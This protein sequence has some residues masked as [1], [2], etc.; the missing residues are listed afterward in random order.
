MISNRE[1]PFFIEFV[2]NSKV[3][4]IPFDDLFIKINPNIIN[5]IK[6]QKQYKVKSNV[7][8]FIFLDFIEYLK[9]KKS[10]K[11]QIENIHEYD[12]LSQ[13][14]EVMKDLVHIYK[15]YENFKILPLESENEELKTEIQSQK[16]ILN[17]KK[18]K[19]KQIINILFFNKGIEKFSSHYNKVKIQEACEQENIDLVNQSSRTKVVANDIYYILDENEKTASISA[20]ETSQ[21]TVNIPRSILF[22]SQEYLVTRILSKAFHTEANYNRNQ[23]Y[24]SINYGPFSALR[25]IDN[26]AFLYCKIENIEIPPSVVE[27]KEGWCIH[28]PSELKKI[29]VMQNNPNFINY[30]DMF[31]LGKSDQQREVFDILFYVNS[32]FEVVVIPSFI[33]KIAPYAFNENKDLNF[34]QFSEDSELQI[35]EK[36]AFFNSS[37][38]E[39]VIPSNV[40]RICECA[41]Q[42]CTNLS[43]VEFAENSQLQIIEKQAFSGTKFREVI[44]PSN[45]RQ[46]CSE[47]FKNR[48]KM[49][50]QLM[51]NN[52][53]FINYK[54]SFILKKSNPKSDLYD[55]LVYANKYISTADIPFFIREISPYAFNECSFLRTIKFSDKSNLRKIGEGAFAFCKFDYIRIPSHVTYIGEKAFE[56]CLRLKKVDFSPNSELRVI[57]NR[58]F[59]NSTILT[60]VI[61][62]LVERLEEYWC[63]Y[64]IEMKE[65]ILSPNNHN[66]MLYE[67]KFLLGKSN[68]KS[69]IFDVLLFVDRS[70]IGSVIIPSFIREIAPYAF[71]YCFD[72][73]NIV[74][75]DDS[76]LEIIHKYAFS[77]IL[78]ESI[79]IP[80][81]VKQIGK[82]AFFGIPF[83]LKHVDFVSNYNSILIH[84]K[85]FPFSLNEFARKLYFIKMPYQYE[86][87]K[88][89][90]K[91]NVF[92]KLYSNFN[93]LYF[94]Y[95][96]FNQNNDQTNQIIDFLFSYLKEYKFISY[97]IT[98]ANKNAFI[99]DVVICAETICV[100]IEKTNI[101]VMNELIKKLKDEKIFI[102]DSNIEN[103]NE[104]II[105]DENLSKLE[106]KNFC[107]HFQKEINNRFIYLTISPIVGY[108][109][110]RFYCPTSF[111][112]DSSFFNFNFDF[113]IEEKLS[114]SISNSIN[115][116]DLLTATFDNISEPLSD[117]LNK[118]NRL[119]VEIN[120]Q[121]NI[122]NFIE[123]DFIIL[124]GIYSNFYSHYYLVFHIDSFHLFMMKKIKNLHESEHEIYFDEHYSH[125]CF[126]KFYGFL[127]EKGEK[128]GF[129]YEF[130]S[131]GSLSSYIL[132][133]Q[134]KTD[135]LFILTTIIRLYQSLFYLYSNNLIHR[136]IKPS[137]ILINNDF[138]TF[139]SDFETIRPLD[140]DQNN[141]NIKNEFTNDLGSLL[142]ISPEQ[143]EGKQISF[144]SDIFSFGLIIF[145][146]FEK[147]N[148]RINC[149]KIDD[150]IRPMKNGSGNIQ[151][152]Y[153][154]CVQNL[155]DKRPNYNDIKSFLSKEI[156]SFEF[157]IDYLQKANYNSIILN[158]YFF[159][160]M[161]ILHDD[162]EMLLDCFKNLVFCE[163]FIR[164]TQELIVA[165]KVV[166]DSKPEILDS[167]HLNNLA[168]EFY[169][170]LKVKQNFTIA[171]KLFEL[172][173]QQNNSNA[174]YNLALLYQRGNGVKQDLL[175]A[176]EYL[177]LSVQSDNP[178]GMS[179]L[180]YYYLTGFVVEQ[181]YTL[182]R[183]CFEMAAEHNVPDAF[184]NLGL[185][186]QYGFGVKHDSDKAIQ[187]YQLS[188]KQN[189]AEA[190]FALGE[191]YHFGIYTQKDIWKAKYYYELAAKQKHSKALNNLG[192][193]YVN[194]SSVQRDYSKGIYYYEQAAKLNN[195]VAL[196]NLGNL[197]QN[198][199]GV[200][201][202][203]LKAKGYYELSASSN[204]PEALY[205]LGNL[206]LNGFGVEKNITRAIN[207]FELSANLN[208]HFALYLLASFYNNGDL[209]DVNYE[210]SI[211]YLK[212]CI[213]IQNGATFQNNLSLSVVSNKLIYSSYNDLGL[214]YLI[215]FQD[216]EKALIYIKKAALA[217]HPFAQSNF[218]LINQ[219]YLNEAG[220]AEYMFKRSSEHKF[221]IAEY[222]IG[223]LKEKEGNIEQAIDYYCSASDHINE[224]L[225]FHGLIQNDKRE[226]ISKIFIICLTNL[227]KGN[228]TLMYM[229][230]SM[231]IKI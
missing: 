229:I 66:F 27:L 11:F 183:A 135:D 165:G 67:N 131:N 18:M 200:Q 35:I 185:V 99:G 136:D 206:Y 222:N 60:L 24:N 57:K 119:H 202:D 216:K 88:M 83:K 48:T 98:T 109:I 72:I 207:Y 178:Y 146:L 124:R 228:Y 227:K 96:F 34:V 160:S 171:R 164:Y 97:C 112:K 110:R 103:V 22:Q 187:Y 7:S 194:E 75:P 226:N 52:E 215:T 94:P 159:E 217:E 37:I 38:K 224:K 197:Y 40:T 92:R 121:A 61:P 149:D 80:S 95:G 71:T 154:L 155:P 50:L 172:A 42:N 142:Y 177:T 76:Q 201:Q 231:H 186:Y 20:I 1:K 148:M 28:D 5:I 211:K 144:S 58:V 13:E 192:M 115:A 33:K 141:P 225:V 2:L 123:K 29:T 86:S 199:I 126:V 132:K 130:M 138:Q 128:V 140:Q 82:Y 203:Y 69:D 59:Y 179:Q 120:H 89:K 108:M 51:P 12:Q 137:N 114:N 188:A 78:F 125:R 181:D 106:I 150:I 101:E 161:I 191:I 198:G 47:C 32:G 93:F 14:F 70:L 139:L 65:I 116:P 122:M 151:N 91:N 113:S 166:P 145:Y 118:I 8:E 36:Y 174:F 49:S 19:Y 90:I 133:K 41:F 21:T 221:A 9:Y 73:T 162:Y 220:N 3:F 105:D 102:I 153:K 45:V 170:G 209:I 6:T 143:F 77:T 169:F 26:S 182:A 16:S 56:K 74:F 63:H 208:Y 190:L 43:R 85:A 212:K 10:P 25:T 147:E 157:L 193:I 223:Y 173:A 195:P 44:I 55:V 64:T 205:S 15:K 175:I 31:L 210:K 158:N 39:I 81:R 107:S 230:I 196:Y 84:P 180:G 17:E 163:Y 129:I 167:N 213:D 54:N 23:K 176:K 53:H 156:N 214:I 117:Y 79:K 87:M 111:F 30:Q 134:D 184:Y 68:P 104:R 218:G 100:M 152:L 46:F 189:Y 62:P 168:T 4:Q 219:F 127:Y 204:Y